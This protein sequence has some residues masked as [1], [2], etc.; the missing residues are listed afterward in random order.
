ML[1]MVRFVAAMVLML[2]V[3]PDS[4]SRAQAPSASHTV[5]RL[6]ATLLEV[7]RNAQTLGFRGRVER[8]GPVLLQI[9]DLRTMGRTAVGGRWDG[10]TPEQQNE[11]I[12]LFGRFTVATYASRFNGFGGESFEVTGEQAAGANTL[13]RSRIVRR[14]GAPVQI[15][16][17]VAGA[18][19]RVIDVYLDS[20]I[21]EVATRRSEFTS[22][23]ARGGIDA[24]TQTLR[25]R[26]ARLEQAAP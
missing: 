4:P 19:R 12:E 10:A 23:I 13:V 3:A 14:T 5:E 9:Y 1:F 24:L 22:I 7:M 15:N 11:I 25:E 6:N 21:S 16:Y 18:G 8:L 17:L 26:I 2:A 20:S